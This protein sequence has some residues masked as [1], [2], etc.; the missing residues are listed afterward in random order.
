MLIH[1][2]IVNFCSCNIGPSL[3]PT[4]IDLSTYGMSETY[5][6]CRW[7]GQVTKFPNNH[8]H[9]CFQLSIFIPITEK[10]PNDLIGRRAK[11]L[12]Y[13]IIGGGMWGAP[14]PGT[15][16]FKN[17][18]FSNNA[19][20]NLENCQFMFRSLALYLN[21]SIFFQVLSP[22]KKKSWIDSCYDQLSKHGQI[23]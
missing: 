2:N 23:W 20:K 17:P 4:I 15:F 18:I 11:L 21:F 6:Y 14:L 7:L 1:D 16:F 9:E 8:H 19:L 5:T 12:L 13:M 10:Y 3:S 22:T